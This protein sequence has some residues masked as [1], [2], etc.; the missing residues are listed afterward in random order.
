MYY[1]IFDTDDYTY[2]ISNFAPS[3]PILRWSRY[4]DISEEYISYRSK[5]YS[6]NADAWFSDPSL[7]NH[8]IVIPIGTSFPELSSIP[9]PSTLQ[10]SH[11]E[12][13]I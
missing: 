3:S 4:E 1:I 8:C 10:V 2:F 6:G 13:F 12:Y 9:S 7:Y 11:P 5:R